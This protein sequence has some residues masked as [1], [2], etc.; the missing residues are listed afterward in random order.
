[1]INNPAK[2]KT[3]NFFISFPPQLFLVFCDQFF[4]ADSI[5]DV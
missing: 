2:L 5:S 4:Y 1:M 3:R